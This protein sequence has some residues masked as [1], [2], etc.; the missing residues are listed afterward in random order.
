[1]AASSARDNPLLL[2]ATA[3]RDR[4]LGRGPRLVC[5]DDRRGVLRPEGRPGRPHRRRAR[6]AVAGPPAGAATQPQLSHQDRRGPRRARAAARRH[7]RGDPGLDRPPHRRA[8]RRVR[9]RRPGLAGGAARRRRPHPAPVARHH[10]RPLR[11][12]A[13]LHRVLGSRHAA[14]CGRSPPATST[15]SWSRCAAT[16]ATTPS[17]RCAR[18]SGSPDDAA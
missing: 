18:C 9:P 12:G 10:L 1:M 15:P 13:A 2:A 11:Q 7:H 3:L 14:T 5:R 8:A 6:P 17:P 4:Q 16:G